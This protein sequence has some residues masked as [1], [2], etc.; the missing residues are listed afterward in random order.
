[1]TKS[2]RLEPI[3]KLAERREQEVARVFAHVLK[4]LEDKRSRLRE[5]LSYA[6]E[7]QRNFHLLIA[8]GASGQEV[9]QFR[10]FLQQL[11]AAI[12]H[13]RDSVATAERICDEERARWLAVRSKTLSLDKAIERFRADEAHQQQRREQRESDDRRRPGGDEGD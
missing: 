11:D 7:Y 5:L 4:Q 10:S 13:Q 6:D 1:M 2:K 12:A 9:Q 8:R 3:V